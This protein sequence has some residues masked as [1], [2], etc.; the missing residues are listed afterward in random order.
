MHLFEVRLSRVV[1]QLQ[2]RVVA[3]SKTKVVTVIQEVY[4]VGHRH[5]GESYVQLL[6]DKALQVILDLLV[7][8]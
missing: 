6:I 8:H 2:V 3:V 1:I 4:D 7:P 5:W